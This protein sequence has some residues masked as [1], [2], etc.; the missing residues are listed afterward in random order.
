MKPF[1]KFISPHRYSPNT[2]WGKIP[3]TKKS[4]SSVKKH[5]DTLQYSGDQG[6]LKVY[7]PLLSYLP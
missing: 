2:K 6:I 4:V 1:C 7:K 5:D 3:L